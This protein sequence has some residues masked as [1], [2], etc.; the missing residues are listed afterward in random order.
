MLGGRV[1]QVKP[2]K[3]WGSVHAELSGLLYLHGGD[4]ESFSRADLRADE[5]ETFGRADG[6][7]ETRAELGTARTAGSETGVELG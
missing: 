3:I 7:S 2:T 1:G 5:S 4:S 6:G